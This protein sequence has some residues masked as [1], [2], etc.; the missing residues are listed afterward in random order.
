MLSVVSGNIPYK[1]KNNIIIKGKLMTRLN[2]IK[3]MV[4]AAKMFFVAGRGRIAENSSNRFAFLFPVKSYMKYRQCSLCECCCRCSM[5][6][7]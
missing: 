2:D 7:C 3:Y 5:P 6:V 4:A 1:K